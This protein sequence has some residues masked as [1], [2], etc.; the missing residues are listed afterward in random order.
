MYTTLYIS[1]IHNPVHFVYTQEFCV[2]TTLHS[3]IHKTCV[4]TKLYQTRPDQ[5]RPDLCCQPVLTTTSHTTTGCGTYVREELPH[6]P[7][8]PTHER[9][10]V[11]YSRGICTEHNVRPMDGKASTQGHSSASELSRV[12]L[13][14]ARLDISSGIL[15]ASCM[16]MTSPSQA[17]APLLIGSKRP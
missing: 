7:N 8:N 4:Y 12:L 5:T 2:Y 15:C 10:L 11:H 13:R 16:A 1:C 17:L 9:E 3:C 6:G 14:R